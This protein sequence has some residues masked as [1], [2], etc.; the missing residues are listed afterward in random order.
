MKGLSNLEAGE[1]RN[2]TRKRNLSFILAA[3]ALSFLCFG[4][5]TVHTLTKR[6]WPEHRYTPVLV[7]GK[8][9][10]VATETETCSQMG[11][12]ILKVCTHY[13]SYRN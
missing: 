8:H 7:K 9:G 6:D 4:Y 12:D 1:N 10:A 13:L 11:V 2:I 5:T 3:I